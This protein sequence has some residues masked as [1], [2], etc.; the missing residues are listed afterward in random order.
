MLVTA[1]SVLSTLSSMLYVSRKLD[2]S[3]E[4]RPC[5]MMRRSSSGGSSSPQ[6]MTTTTPRVSSP[7][8]PA[9][10][11]ICVYSPGSRLRKL[12]PSCLRKPLKT[13]ARAGKDT[14][15]AKV[16]VVKSSLMRPR[17]K[18]I[19]THSFMMGSSPEWCTPSPRLSSARSPTICG[20]RRSVP[21]RRR[22]AASMNRWIAPFSR[23]VV[24]S[25][26]ASPRNATSSQRFLEKQKQIVGSSCSFC[27]SATRLV[28]TRLSSGDVPPPE[29]PAV[30]PRCGPYALA[31]P[32]LSMR[33]PSRSDAPR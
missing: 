1:R 19:S 16:S 7:R 29:R 18:S 14:P 8:R 2:C 20:S 26:D 6:H 11:A 24:R 9:R 27:S 32:R 25:V 13:T 28:H 33:A 5:I 21:L 23:A 12:V 4:G 22:T 3:S 10:P 17:A 31:R 30:L 15:M